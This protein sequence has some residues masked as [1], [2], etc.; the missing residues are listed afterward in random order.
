MRTKSKTQAMKKTLLLIGCI[1]LTSCGVW[2]RQ[3]SVSTYALSI[4]KL[5]EHLSDPNVS[6]HTSHPNW[7]CT[8]YKVQKR[9]YTNT[10]GKVITVRV[11]VAAD[12]KAPTY[13]QLK[14]ELGWKKQ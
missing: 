1:T 12:R 10:M 13:Q 11:R 7:D 4:H 3:P 2:K 5:D 9:T 8:R 6:L 14:Q